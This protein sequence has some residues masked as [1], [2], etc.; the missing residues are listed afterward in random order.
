[1]LGKLSNQIDL[2]IAL[3][4]IAGPGTVARALSAINR[5]QVSTLFVPEHTKPSAIGPFEKCVSVFHA[6][7]VAA[8]GAV[9][10]RHNHSFADLG[11]TPIRQKSIVFMDS[12]WTPIGQV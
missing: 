6:K 2:R 5:E 7:V 4:V 8:S 12:T 1:M 9:P 3:N 10:I 11:R